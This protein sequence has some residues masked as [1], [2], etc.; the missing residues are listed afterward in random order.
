MSELIFSGN[1]LVAAALAL[2]AGL[3]SFLSP[4]VLPLVPGYLG[5]LATVSGN[6]TAT[7][8]K[9]VLATFLFVLGFSAVFT[10]YGIFFGSLG[11]LLFSY[12]NLIERFLGVLVIILGFGF[13]FQSGWLSRS[14]KINFKV[15]SGVWG[16]P[17]L[18][19]LFAFGW[20]P[21]IGPVLAAVQTMAFS[22]GT[23]AKG[24]ALS[25]VYAM[26]LGIPFLLLAFIY[27]RSITTVQFLRKYQ[28]VFMRFGAIVLITIGLLLVTGLWSELTINLR[29][30]IAQFTPVI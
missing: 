10:S 22:E 18:G 6:S 5:Y 24:A 12:A 3:V 30:W 27:E 13:L 29:I 8:R 20:T 19:A 25:F 14:Y 16:A 23:A 7:K 2:L 15:K 11:S 1:F 17:L 26:G 9:A 4:C 28:L 21:C